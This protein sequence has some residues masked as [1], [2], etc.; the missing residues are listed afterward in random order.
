[1]ILEN[2]NAVIYG[3]SGA[4]GTT[5]ARAF[6]KDGATVFLTGRRLAPLE[7][8]AKEITADGGRA[9]AAIVDALDESAIS[10]HLDSVTE[11]S[12]AIDI[13]FNAIGIPQEGVQGIPLLALSSEGFMLPVATYAKSHFLTGR[14]AAKRMVPRRTG[15]II[16]L[17]AIPARIAAPLV[18]GM[19][20][21]WAALESL[22]RTMASELGSSGV[23]VVCLRADGMPET[24]TITEVYGLHATGAGMPSHKE[25][26]SVMESMTILKR[27][28]KLSELANVAAFIAS[29]LA[30]AMTG[31]TINVSCGSV[32][33]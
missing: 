28:P 17:T 4:I 15:V 18:G 33:D 30:N 7:A 23:R 2:K 1:M 20:A 13:S 19:G 16:M 32:A 22:T 21:A 6:A 26:Q 14:E 27:L 31:T 29:D 10:S 8:L 25:F 9:H 3:A 11:K 12:G 5:V 24:D